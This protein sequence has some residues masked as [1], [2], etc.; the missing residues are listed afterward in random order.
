MYILINAERQ[1]GRILS[2]VDRSSPALCWSL[3]AVY[4]ACARCVRTKAAARLPA[5]TRAAS[6][7]PRGVGS[8]R[9]S[10]A[11]RSA[12][13][14]LLRALPPRLFGSRSNERKLSRVPGSTIVFRRKIVN[15]FFL[16]YPIFVC[17]FFSQLSS[18]IEAVASE[19]GTRRGERNYSGARS[20][21]DRAARRPIGDSRPAG[22]RAVT[23]D[24]KNSI[25][26][27]CFR[28][29]YIYFFLYR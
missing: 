11:R 6:S 21:V 17:M 7:P 22:R 26:P 13:L 16:F 19:G 4:A 25:E 23:F 12:A 14:A 10:A 5:G 29:I 9:A 20:L 18:W 1:H 2:S 15:D 28:Q 27:F 24:R 8:R 3:C